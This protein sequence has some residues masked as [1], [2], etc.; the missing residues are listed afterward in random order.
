MKDSL[1]IYVNDKDNNT[2]IDLSLAVKNRHNDI[3]VGT[4]ILGSQHDDYSKSMACRFSKRIGKVVYF[5]C[6]IVQDRSLV[7]LMEK[8]ILEEIKLHPDK[9]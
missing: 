2:F 3:P 7:P 4:Q 5:S 6:N 9:F 8:R 1:L